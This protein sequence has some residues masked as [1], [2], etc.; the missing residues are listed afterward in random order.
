VRFW[1]NKE[2]T[3]H[4]EFQAAP[5]MAQEMVAA[6]V[7]CATRKTAIVIGLVEAAAFGTDS[8]HQFGHGILGNPWRIDSIEVVEDRSKRLKSLVHRLAC[9]PRNLAIDP[10]VALDEHARTETWVSATGQ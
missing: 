6:R 10:K 7:V 4:I 9:S 5:K 2:A 3:P 8:G 1:P